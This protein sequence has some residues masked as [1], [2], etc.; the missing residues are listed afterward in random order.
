LILFI[1]NYFHITIFFCVDAAIIGLSFFY[2]GYLF[3]AKGIIDYFKN[4]KKN[5]LFL[6]L[7]LI[8]ALLVYTSHSSIKFYAGKWTG[9]L[10]FAYIGSFSGIFMVV[11]FTN[12]ISNI[13]NKLI[14][15][16]SINTLTIMGLE[17]F[18]RRGVTFALNGIFIKIHP[19]IGLC[20]TT[21][22]ILLISVFFATLINKFYPNLIGNPPNN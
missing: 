4:K 3:K 21:F 5:V 19:L 12:I 1:L 13:N 8:I 15:L 17:K 7:F 2:A 10:I 9:N 14:Y 22:L 11:A 18:L 16:I 6:V 20:I